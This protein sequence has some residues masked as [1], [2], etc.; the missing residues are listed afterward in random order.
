M[1]VEGYDFIV[2]YTPGKTVSIADCL[3]RVSPRPSKHIEGIDLNVHSMM[4]YFN[5]SPTRMETIR[6]ETLQDPLLKELVN[7]VMSGWPTNR[8]DC[9]S[10]L[11]P[12]WNF[13]DEIGVQDDI[14]LKSNKIIIPASLQR[15]ILEELHASHQGVEKTRLRARSVLYWVGMNKDIEDIVLNCHTCQ[16]YQASIPAE[17]I[18]QH[19]IPTYPWQYVSTDLFSMAGRE[20]LLVADQY[21]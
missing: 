19:E 6:V 14:L 12:F 5:F 10:Y 4:T 20:Y 8:A 7:M 18:H 9:P 15:G 13:R 1:K 3:S 16:K 21:S 11:L 2:K 17:S